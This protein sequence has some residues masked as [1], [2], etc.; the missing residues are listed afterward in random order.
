MPELNIPSLTSQGRSHKTGDA[1]QESTQP[2]VSAQEKQA[3]PGHELTS[4]R[5]PTAFVAFLVGPVESPVKLGVHKELACYHSTVLR[6]A[7]NSDFLAG[8]SA[9][10]YGHQDSHQSFQFVHAT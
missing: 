5:E 1:K 4:E 8:Q 3:L 6:A 9:I 10:L 7:F 2:P